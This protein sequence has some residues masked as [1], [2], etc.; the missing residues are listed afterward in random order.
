MKRAGMGALSLTTTLMA[1]AVMLA[2]ESAYARLEA[3]SPEAYSNNVRTST[4]K[5]AVFARGAVHWGSE[6]L[7][8]NIECMQVMWGYVHNEGTPAIGQG[9]IMGWTG[10]GDAAGEG[11]EQRRSCKFTKAGVEGE[12]EAS[13]TDE[14]AIETTR[15]PPSVPW[16]MQYVCYEAEGSRR[17]LLKVG[18]PSAAPPPA[19]GCA[20]E[21]ER[22]AEIEKEETERTGCYA[23]TV[24]EGCVKLTWVVPGL[25]LESTFEG[26]EQPQWRNG[27]TNGLHMSAWEFLGAQLGKLHL[28]GVFSTTAEPSGTT[29]EPGFSMQLITAK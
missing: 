9:Q 5:V 17:A 4:S 22:A 23:T 24:P 16:N 15:R 29:R 18:I 12:P 14:P 13:I 28:R 20:T 19:A 3:G 10:Q 7:G 25:G 8:A 1:I 2:P 11:I 6:A 21:A 26:T 27:F